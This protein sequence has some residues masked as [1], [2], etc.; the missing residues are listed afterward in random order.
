MGKE[1]KAYGLR[2]PKLDWSCETSV[3]KRESAKDASERGEA[4]KEKRHAERTQQIRGGRGRRPN[5]EKRFEGVGCWVTNC[6]ASIGST[7]SGPHF[8]SQ[9]LQLL[10]VSSSVLHRLAVVGLDIVTWAG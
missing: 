9:Q 4:R 7:A 5:R 8:L 6:S 2:R 10:R 1:E 3:D